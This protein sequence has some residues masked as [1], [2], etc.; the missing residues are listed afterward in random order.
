MMRLILAFIILGISIWAG[1]HLHQNP[2]YV[3]IAIAGWTVETTVWFAIFALLLAFL[4]LH[5][6]LSLLQKPALW[7]DRI[8]AWR[9]KRQMQKA[10]AASEARDHQIFEQQLSFSTLKALEKTGTN[11]E[12]DTFFQKMSRKLRN[13]PRMK[14]EYLH[15]L[16]ESG[17][18][19]KAEKI[20][21]KA[22]HKAPQDQGL[23]AL[24]GQCYYSQKQIHFAES[25]LNHN[26]ASANLYLCL[27]RLCMH[28]QFWGKAKNYLEKSLSLQPTPKAHEELARLYEH[29]EDPENAFANYKEGLK[30]VEGD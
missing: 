30:L 13:L 27:G 17:Q 12:V 16:I 26:T 8:H 23:I 28:W 21:R 4:L 5:A 2:G 24:Y 22:L 19:Q 9:E 29:I 18:H 7:R 15:Y 11:E 6:F 25:L 10:L 1:V 20:L 14:E 3:L